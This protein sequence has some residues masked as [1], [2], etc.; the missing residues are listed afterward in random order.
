MA[1]ARVDARIIEESLTD[2]LE[3]VRDAI[4]WVKERR[5]NI[6][7]EV[8]EPYEHILRGP[9]AGIA[10]CNP[11]DVCG[12]VGILLAVYRAMH[13]EKLIKVSRGKGKTKPRK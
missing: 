2:V 10:A 12:D 6:T 9:L 4:D 7:L 1:T 5:G 13:P 11:M 8:P 3:R